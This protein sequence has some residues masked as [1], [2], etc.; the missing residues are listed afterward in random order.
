[1]A[2]ALPAFTALIAQT[3]SATVAQ[4]I[5]QYRPL[6]MGNLQP[7][8]S[9]SGVFLPP[10]PWPRLHHIR[11]LGQM[12]WASVG[13]H[14]TSAS[15][16]LGSRAH[17]AHGTPRCEHMMQYADLCIVMFTA[18]SAAVIA[19]TVRLHDFVIIT[20]VLRRNASRERGLLASACGE[21]PLVS[22]AV[23]TRSLSFL[24]QSSRLCHRATRDPSR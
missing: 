5:V 7:R 11:P 15:L 10:W 24:G 21:P 16:G 9:E 18:P 17:R 3:R 22:S 6:Q 8:G 20:I 23:Y 14:V 19:S 2:T 1:M 12:C 13:M 4:Y